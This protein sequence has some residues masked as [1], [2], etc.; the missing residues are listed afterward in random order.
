MGY[1]NFFFEVKSMSLPR[2]VEKFFPWPHQ[3]VFAVMGLYTGLYG[4]GKILWGNPL[5]PIPEKIKKD[6]ATGATGPTDTKTGYHIPLEADLDAFFAKSEI[7]DIGLEKMVQ[8]ANLD[9]F[10][11]SGA[12][13]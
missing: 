2:I 7:F 5:P 8:E 13:Q 10:V 4:F 9:G 3:R 1:F 12:A 6:V 11:E